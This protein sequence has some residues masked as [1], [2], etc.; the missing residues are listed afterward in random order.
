[1]ATANKSEALKTLRQAIGEIVALEAQKKEV[2]TQL[3]DLK[4]KCVDL[5]LG[6]DTDEVIGDT[7]RLTLIKATT[8][9]INQDKLADV[10]GVERFDDCCRIVFDQKK[11]EDQMAIGNITADEVAKAAYEKEKKP[12][13]RLY[14]AAG[15]SPDKEPVEAS[16]KDV[17]SIVQSKGRRK[18]RTNT[19]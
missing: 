12:Y 19:R 9:E 4:A 5:M 14:A 6:I 1:M 10:I 16:L 17:K 15:A 8:L 3:D 2:T 7:H 11:L 18:T 13:V